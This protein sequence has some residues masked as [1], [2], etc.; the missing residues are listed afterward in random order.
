MHVQ[1]A[2]EPADDRIVVGGTARPPVVEI[3][4]IWLSG[5]LLSF[6]Y[7][8]PIYLIRAVRDFYRIRSRL[9]GDRTLPR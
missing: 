4:G 3:V 7:L 5:L 9:R 2:T 6:I 8:A 1:W